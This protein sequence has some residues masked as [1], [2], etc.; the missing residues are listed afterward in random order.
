MVR[1]HKKSRNRNSQTG[2]EY[3][4]GERKQQIPEISNASVATLALPIFW[5]KYPPATQPTAPVAIVK[6]LNSDTLSDNPFPWL[7]K[8]TIMGM[9]PQ[10]V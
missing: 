2:K 4:A 10:K 1:P 8:P 5:D 7:Y 6:K 9:N 3:K